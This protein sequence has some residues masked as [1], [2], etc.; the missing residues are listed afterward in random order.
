M[1]RSYMKLPTRSTWK[2]TDVTWYHTSF[3]NQLV[4]LTLIQSIF[5]HPWPQNSCRQLPPGAAGSGGGSWP[6]WVLL[7]CA[8]DASNASHIK[9]R[10]NN[11]WNRKMI[12][13]CW[14][15]IR[16]PLWWEMILTIYW[17]AINN[18]IVPR[19][20][21]SESSRMGPPFSSPTLNMLHVFVDGSKRKKTS[22]QMP[23]PRLWEPDD[24]H[25]SATIPLRQVGYIS[26]LGS[27]GTF[28]PFKE[29]GSRGFWI[30]FNL[31]I[32]FLGGLACFCSSACKAM[33]MLAQKNGWLT[34]GVTGLMF[35]SIVVSW[36]FV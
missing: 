33:D 2:Y 24:L 34:F 9:L 22:R 20:P 29:P 16:M 21:K 5:P 27:F 8:S 28:Y 6:Q 19:S 12:T 4:Y 26:F 18:L 10:S 13:R 15:P 36:H 7:A 1:N 11:L 35:A 25:R 17:C 32:C 31:G 30:I 23:F 3:F 14:L